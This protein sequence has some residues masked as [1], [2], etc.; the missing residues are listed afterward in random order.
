V[1][2]PQLSGPIEPAWQ[3]GDDLTLNRGQF[4]EH[5]AAQLAAVEPSKRETVDWLAAFGSEV[6]GV[7]PKK[8]RMS[9][10]EIRAIGGGQQ[11]FLGTMRELAAGTDAGHLR[12]TLFAPWDYSD[13]RPSMRWDP[14]DYRPHALR[15][16]NP[17]KAPIK[18]MRGANLLAVQALPLFP[19][20]PSG[21]RA[22]TTG[23]QVRDG[24]TEITWPIWIDPLDVNTISSLLASPEVQEADRHTMIRRGIVQIFRARRYTEGQYRNF[25]PAKTL[26]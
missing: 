16:D 12:R 20:V 6:Y 2:E 3:V 25:S 21:G 18:T 14:A 24:R 23:F 1:L 9:D 13:D 5:L 19:V 4:R 15:A 11:C 22:H 26:L 10:T 8:E 7:G 17:S